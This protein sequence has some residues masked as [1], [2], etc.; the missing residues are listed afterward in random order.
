MDKPKIKRKFKE[1]DGDPEI[2]HKRKEL[3]AELLSEK[4]KCDYSQLEAYHCRSLP[5]WR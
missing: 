5:T 3:H 2:K 1:L 4:I